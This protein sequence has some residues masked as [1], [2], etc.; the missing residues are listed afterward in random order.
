MCLLKFINEESA[1]I[2]EIYS[3]FTHRG[4]SG[5]TSLVTNL[6]SILAHKYKKK[7]LIIDADPKGNISMA[8]DKIP[9]NFEDT[10]YDVMVRGIDPKE[11]IVSLHQN[12][13]LIPSNGDMDFLE[14]DIFPRLK[15]YS[16]PYHLLKD[17]MRSIK[18]KYDYVFIDTPSSSILTI[19][20]C[21][22]YS[23]KVIIPFVPD[24]FDVAGF[25][26]VTKTIKEIQN[27][28][29]P[30]LKI[31][32]ILAM[33]VEKATNIHK[34]ILKE[35]QIFFSQSNIQLYETRIPKTIL[36]AKSVSYNKS[37]AILTSKAK[38][39]LVNSYDNLANEFLL[40]DKI[41]RK[42]FDYKTD[43]LELYKKKEENK[44]KNKVENTHKRMTFLIR[45]ELKKRLDI[46]SKNKHGFKTFILNQA[47]E[48]ILD[49]TE[50]NDD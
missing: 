17:N 49:K 38:N 10:I 11:V 1:N 31:S 36:F 27:T 34:E 35:A 6:A 12:I 26:Q 18:N 39:K 21:L 28:H 29:N 19:A 15:V 45:K 4:G 20:N 33:K 2:A 30:K 32:G 46:I 14:F 25:S 41:T 44:Q 42:K 24:I 37:P 3:I 47:I 8:F 48:E 13:D 9:E 16:R 40:K 43:I 7:I 22:I 50:R 5:K 23:D